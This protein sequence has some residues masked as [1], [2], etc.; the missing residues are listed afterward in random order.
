MSLT[1]A[2]LR[3]IAVT[4][5]RFLISSDAHTPTRVGDMVCAVKLLLDAKVDL[6]SVVNLKVTE[7]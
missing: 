3:N 7:A 6:D 1:A 5:A 4:E 2:D